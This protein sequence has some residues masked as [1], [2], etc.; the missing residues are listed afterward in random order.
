MVTM[1][2][3]GVW[4]ASWVVVK[5]FKVIRRT[6]STLLESSLLSWRGRIGPST[7]IDPALATMVSRFSGKWEGP[8]TVYSRYSSF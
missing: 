1:V 6:L 4:V 7:L 2:V 8:I 5:T 3:I